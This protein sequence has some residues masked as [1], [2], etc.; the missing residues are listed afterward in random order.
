MQSLG[1][2]GEQVDEHFA[3]EEQGLLPLCA[4]F[5]SLEEWGALPGHG[6]SHF[7]GDKVW[8]I[9]GLIRQRMSEPQREAMLLHMPPPAVEMWTNFGEGA[10][11]ALITDMG[12]PLG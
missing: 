4:E 11:T 7:E 8:S 9:L 6:L 10:F 3:D 1:K 2:L 12:A 5:L